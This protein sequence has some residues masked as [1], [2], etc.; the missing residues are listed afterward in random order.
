MLAPNCTRGATPAAMD[1]T[2]A[3]T[4]L[5]P[6]PSQRSV[7]TATVTVAGGRIRPSSI[8]ANGDATDEVVRTEFGR[9]L[10]L[11]AVPLVPPPLVPRPLPLCAV[12]GAAA[13][14]AASV[15]RTLAATKLCRVIGRLSRRRRDR[16]VWWT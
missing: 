6:V 11:G 1:V 8:Q 14:S 15:V 2:G 12:A 3:S 7:E 4:S 13:T 5:A 16:R 10:R 9:V